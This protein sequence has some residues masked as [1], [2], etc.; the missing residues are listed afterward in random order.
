MEKL[1][2]QVS[3]SDERGEI[4]DLLEH[5]NINAITLVSFKKGALRG[6]H[7]HKKTMQWIYIMSGSIKIV[8][9]MPGEKPVESIM[10]RGDFFVNIPDERHALLALEDSQTIVFT[11]G[12]RGGKEYESDTFRLEEPLI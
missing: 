11:K 9:Q 4:I 10:K 12:P 8:S 5:E 3:Q 7:Y 1:N 6:N 2:I